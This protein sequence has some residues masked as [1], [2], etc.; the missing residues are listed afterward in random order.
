MIN[1]YC[2]TQNIHRCT[3]VLPESNLLHVLGKVF[4]WLIA[5]TAAELF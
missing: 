2:I 3:S 1:V 5:L 4:Q